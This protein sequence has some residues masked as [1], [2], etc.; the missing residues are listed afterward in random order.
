MLGSINL[1][2]ALYSDEFPEKGETIFGKDFFMNLGGKG[3]NQ[4]VAAKKAEG[5]MTLIGRVGK[6]YFGEI[7]LKNRISK[8]DLLLL[9]GEIP[10]DVLLEAARYSISVGASV[11]FDPALRQ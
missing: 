4:A 2:L 9:Q 6:D 3:A 5:D 11:I 1:D 7:V 8:N 10:V